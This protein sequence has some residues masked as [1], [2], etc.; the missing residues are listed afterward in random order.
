MS[1]FHTTVH[2]QII[3]Y[4]RYKV[5][6]FRGGQ[7]STYLSKWK[8]LTTDQTILCTVRGEQFEFVSSPPHQIGY[9]PNSISK[10][11]KS[12]LDQ[13]TADLLQRNIIVACDHE[14]GEFISPIFIVPKKDGKI[15]LILNL[16]KLNM[17]IKNSHFK[18]IS[19]HSIL[20]L[21]TPNCWMASLD[22]KDAYYSV[23]IDPDFQKY[24]KFWYNGKLYKY[25]VFPNGLCV[26]P[27]SF[28]KLLKPPL[29]HLRLNKH[30][31]CG[32]IDDFYLQGKTQSDCVENVIDSLNM[33]DSLGFVIH[34]DKSNFVPTQVIVF[35]GFE[36]N[37]VEMKVRLT[38]SKIENFKTLLRETISRAHHIMI[39]SI[40]QVI[41]HM[42]SSLPG[43]QFGPLHYRY[44]Q[45]NTIQ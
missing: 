37:S 20:R 45:Y 29:A 23:Q 41:G 24:L 17:Y 40:A 43:V 9:A 44:L 3:P 19:I 15:R 22:L 35:L 4:L 26:C 13:E 10:E 1:D 33:L 8:L 6:T 11:H 34:P 27:R 42:I 38:S 28:T 18:M 2:S 30:I 25:T 16:K 21:V 12:L 31:I 39:K 14:P 7:L 32:Y 5:D 36:I